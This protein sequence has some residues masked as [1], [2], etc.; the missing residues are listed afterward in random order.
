M[1]WDSL[2]FDLMQVI[3]KYVRIKKKI[4]LIVNPV[5]PTLQPY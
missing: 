5:K 1:G 2:I 3:A 4:Y